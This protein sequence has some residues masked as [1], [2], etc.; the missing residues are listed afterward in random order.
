VLLAKVN[1]PGVLVAASE[2]GRDLTTLETEW[3]EARVTTWVHALT[4]LDD[5]R[6]ELRGSAALSGYPSGAARQGGF[7][8]VVTSDWSGGTSTTTLSAVDL[9]TVEVTSRQPVDGAWAWLA[10]AAGGKLLLQAGWNDQ[11]VLVYGLAAPARPAFE[12]FVRT[13]GWVQDIVVGGG[14]AYLPSGAYGVP[15]I[16]LAP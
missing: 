9:S 6:A 4:L 3:G 2:D 12:Q 7:A 10:Q 8:W 16:D 13:Q 5:G 15:M 14:V 1:V 11:G